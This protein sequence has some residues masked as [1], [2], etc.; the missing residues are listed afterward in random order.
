MHKKIYFPVLS[1]TFVLKEVTAELGVVIMLSENMFFFNFITH[2]QKVVI[3]FILSRYE[4]DLAFL[5]TRHQ[6]K[7]QTYSPVQAGNTLTFKYTI[8]CT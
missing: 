7:H 5:T 3:F 4:L 1:E 2:T 6:N 8:D